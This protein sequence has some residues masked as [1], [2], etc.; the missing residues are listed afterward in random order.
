MLESTLSH[1]NGVLATER[2]LAAVYRFRVVLTPAFRTS[3]LAHDVLVAPSAVGFVKEV[4]ADE[5]QKVVEIPAIANDTLKST[6]GNRIRDHFEPYALKDG[7]LFHAE[8]K[9]AL[10]IMYKAEP[11][12]ENTDAGW[13]YGTVSADGQTVTSAGRVQSCM[14]CHQDAPH[15]RLFGLKEVGK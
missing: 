9:N 10:F 5:A 13:V 14:Q 6:G 7:K 2:A 12:T 4:N 11:K 1:K 3:P 8:V 15:G